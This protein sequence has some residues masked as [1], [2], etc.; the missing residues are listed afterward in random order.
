MNQQSFIKSGE[1]AGM[2]GGMSYMVWQF[3]SEKSLLQEAISAIPVVI[4]GGIIGKGISKIVSTPTG[5]FMSGT[6]AVGVGCMAIKCY[7]LPSFKFLVDPTNS[8]EAQTCPVSLDQH[9]PDQPSYSVPASQQEYF[10][11][12]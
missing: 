9:P 4:L 12:A 2:I 7:C 1:I 8:S 10:N 11:T 6:F 3:T 5:M